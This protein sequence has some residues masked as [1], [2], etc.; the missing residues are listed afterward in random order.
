[1][2]YGIYELS[3]DVVNPAPDKRRATNAWLYRPVW[4]KGTRL[5]AVPL[6]GDYMKVV[7]HAGGHSSFY[8]PNRLPQ[9]LVA[10]MQPILPRNMYEL[11]TLL[12]TTAETV[13][14]R[15]LGDGVIT[16]DQIIGTTNVPA[17]LW[18][19]LKRGKA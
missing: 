10:A 17:T 5:Y 13:L 16:D 2:K 8:H 4:P 9:I 11:L 6:D 19:S 7:V 3:A 12:D 15:L 18:E 14:C 1:M